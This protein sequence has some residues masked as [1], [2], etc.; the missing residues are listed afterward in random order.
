[1]KILVFREVC[2]DRYFRADTPEEIQQ[3][4]LQVLRERFIDSE[5]AI[6]RY[7]PITAEMPTI[8]PASET[9]T[10]EDLRLNE[11][12]RKLYNQDY[13]R[14]ELENRYYENVKKEIKNPEGK[15]FDLLSRR[16]NVKYEG[17]WIS[18]VG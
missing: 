14:F 16:K 1:M 8:W 4:C 6:Y 9:L 18:E 11:E 10:G 12:K 7:S 13:K 17:F 5:G 3:S 2:G 15:A